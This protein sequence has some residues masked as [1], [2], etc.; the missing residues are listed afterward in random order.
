[1]SSTGG[2]QG[3]Y[4]APALVESA[5]SKKRLLMNLEE[6]TVTSDHHQRYLATV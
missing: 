2:F 5:V 3:K 4:G 1:M 6:D